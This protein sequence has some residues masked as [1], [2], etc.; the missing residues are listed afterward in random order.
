LDFRFVFFYLQELLKEYP[1]GP[2]L[3]TYAEKIAVASDHK[4]IL[5]GFSEW[6]NFAFPKSDL[7]DSR[8]AL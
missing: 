8:S 3:I 7:V 6:M 4:I 5:Q 2:D 1:I